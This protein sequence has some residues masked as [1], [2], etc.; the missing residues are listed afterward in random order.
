MNLAEEFNRAIQQLL[1]R[2]DGVMSLRFIL[3]PTVAAVMAVR[4]GVKDAREGKPAYL[5]EVFTNAQERWRLLLS[6]WKDV[7]KVFTLAFMLDTVYQ[8]I[9]L[10]TYY[11]VQA[12]IIAATLAFVPYLLIRG[13]L[14][15][16]IRLY[17]K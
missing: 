14:T 7:A 1:E 4:A 12:L 13:P 2:P 16:V 17:K 3:Q 9:Q 5:W 6:G 15:R 8:L 10:K 11:P